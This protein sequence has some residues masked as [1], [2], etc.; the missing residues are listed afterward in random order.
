MTRNTTLTASLSALCLMTSALGQAEAVTRQPRAV[1]EPSSA[2]AGQRFGASAAMDSGF[3]VFGAPGANRVGL[4]ERGSS[5]SW[6]EFGFITANDLATGDEFGFAVA[7]DGDLVIVGAP[8]AAGAGSAD[9]GAVYVFEE[10]GN[11]FVQVAKLTAADGAAGDRFGASIAIDGD[12]IVV[13]SPLADIGGAANRGAVYVFDNVGGNTWIESAKVTAGDGAAE[14]RFGTS[15]ATHGSRLLAGAPTRAATGG[16]AC[17]F[18]LSGGAWLASATLVSNEGS[19]GLFGASVALS[20]DWTGDYAFVGGPGLK[21][22]TASTGAAFAYRAES[23]TVW[24]QEARLVSADKAAGDSFGASVAA[25]DD[26]VAVGA[27]GDTVRGTNRAGSATVFRR[28][29]DGLWQ[30]SAKLAAASGIASSAFGTSVALHGERVMVGAPQTAN[31]GLAYHFKIDCSK[32]SVDDNGR[33][34]LFWFNPAVGKVSYWTMDGLAR[35]GA[36]TVAKSLG[37]SVK[38]HGVADFYGNGKSAVLL[39]NKSNGSFRLWRLSGSQL[40]LDKNISTAVGP[41]WNY[42]ATGDISGDG[43]A[44]ILLRQATTGAVKGWLM[45]GA[46]RAALGDV[47][48]SLGLTF[49]ACIDV[50]ADARA[51]ILWR[52]AA[53]TVRA[54]IMNGLVVASEATIGGVDPVGP[55]WVPVG[56]GDLDGDG[57]DDLLWRDRV[58]NI[59]AG[60]LLQDATV[61]SVATVAAIPAGLRVE[62]TADLDGDGDEDIVWRNKLTGGVEGS[63]M[64]G[65]VE[66]S[67]G[68]IGSRPTSWSCMN[69]DDSNDD[70]GSD[71]RGDDDNDDDDDNGGDETVGGAE[72]AASLNAGI[73]ASSLPV[74]EAEAELEG[75]TTFVEIIQWNAGTGQL[76]KVLVHATTG[77]VVS[78]VSW[79]PSSGELSD[80]SEAIAAIPQVTVSPAAALNAAL[81]ARPGTRPHSIELEYEDGFADGGDD[82]DDD[83]DNGGILGPVWK[84]ELANPNGT[85]FEYAVPAM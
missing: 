78:V 55:N 35:Q 12:R 60:W 17:M 45:S 64:S 83:D 82:G 24:T 4:F 72:F 56:A 63:L 9:Q 38:Y 6:E 19:G 16:A 40:L 2:T 58:A 11:E 57:D 3:A 67:R 69:D 25:Y 65:L 71:G 27:P 43:K 80:Y 46:N 18:R 26:R 48:N 20:S 1:L 44:D 31:G 59:L 5:N 75:G 15:V 84:I 23:D 74:L 37:T 62:C 52:D 81:A 76:V 51:D 21:N 73:A 29:G 70:D 22:G 39:R 50:N 47:G 49:V 77:E 85:T 33:D 41:T 7:F 79:T 66:D 32:P 61:V 28:S 30:A 13:G 14:D 42:L 10:S 36:G 54:W 53:G 34:D 8:A 68:S